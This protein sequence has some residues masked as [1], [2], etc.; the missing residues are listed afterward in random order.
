MEMTEM[1]GRGLARPVGP[2]AGSMVGVAVGVGVTAKT[3][4]MGDSETVMFATSWGGAEWWRLSRDTIPPRPSL[5]HT[6]RQL[7]GVEST[8][9]PSAA[10]VS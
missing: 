8:A 4:V 1:S 10:Q 6:H 3:Q 7:Q 5:L 9:S 2:G